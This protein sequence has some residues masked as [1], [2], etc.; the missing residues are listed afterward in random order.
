MDYVRYAR[1]WILLGILCAI[2][3]VKN[4]ASTGFVVLHKVVEDFYGATPYEIDLLVIIGNF[5][6]FPVT[7]LVGYFS[8]SLSLRSLVI[9]MI[10]CLL[11]GSVICLIGFQSR[12]LFYVTE[13]GRIFMTSTAGILYIAQVL[14]AASWFPPNQT[15][16]AFVLPITMFSIA[17]I[18]SALLFPNVIPNNNPA[19][20]T[21]N[22]SFD[23]S[24]FHQTRVLFSATFGAIFLIM[25]VCLLLS[26]LFFK[27]RPPTPPSRSQEKKMMEPK[28]SS[29]SRLIEMCRIALMKPV[30]LITLG[31][32]FSEGAVCFGVT[33]MPSCLLETFPKLDNITAGNI[34]FLRTLATVAATF[35]TGRIVDKFTNFKCTALTGTLISIFSTVG[36]C[37]A[38]ALELLN[39][40]YFL[41]V[42]LMMGRGIFIPA[43]YELLIETTY[44]TNKILMM[45]IN[46]SLGNLSMFMLTTILRTVMEYYSVTVAGVA[47]IFFLCISLVSVA[48]VEPN[49][50]RKRANAYTIL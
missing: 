9:T 47:T 44:P 35:V 34:A 13:I 27:N 24:T 31:T 4:Y 10:S 23:I 50:R 20:S 7:L 3:F 22:S 25:I 39:M 15:A 14:L 41:Y 1:R 49:Y 28:Q 45:S 33:L 12:D 8:Q 32:M 17:S 18:T 30:M 29:G 21:H 40:M 46:S 36:L 19:N 6:A 11:C 42:L 37:F 38:H 48:L 43:V 16:T 2:A 26:I 5:I